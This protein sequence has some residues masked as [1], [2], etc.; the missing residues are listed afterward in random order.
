MLPLSCRPVGVR[1]AAAVT[2]LAA[3]ATGFRRQFRVLRETALFVRHALTAFA[4]RHSRE[5]AV[6]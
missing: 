5:L 3:L 2:G 4:A 6:L 1:A